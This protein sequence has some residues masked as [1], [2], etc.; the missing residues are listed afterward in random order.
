ML[1]FLQELCAPFYLGLCPD[2][3]QIEVLHQKSGP[4]SGHIWTPPLTVISI[5][6]EDEFRRKEFLTENHLN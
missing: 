2:S 1:R 6:A 4:E 3:F 5:F